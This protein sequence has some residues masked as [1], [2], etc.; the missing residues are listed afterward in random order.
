MA[1]TAGSGSAFAVQAQGEQ[2][3]QAAHEHETRRSTIH[4]FTSDQVKRLLSLIETPKPGLEKLS[5]KKDWLFDSGAS[6]HMTV[7]ELL[8]NVM[9]NAPVSVGLADGSIAHAT[10]RGSIQL[11]SKLILRDVLY[12]PSLDCNLISI[13]QLLDELCCMV[14]FT[15]RLCV[16]QDLTTKN[17]IGVDE[18][19]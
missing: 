18:P 10:K 15:K 14:T 5:G 11:N 6:Y 19:K 12:V 8:C 2:S 7:L 1:S 9:D 4:G 16:V 13:Y 3:M 17:M